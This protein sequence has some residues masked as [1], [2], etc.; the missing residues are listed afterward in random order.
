M[1]A[2]GANTHPLG[3]KAGCFIGV[4]RDWIRTREG[5]S[6]LMLTQP[7]ITRAQLRRIRLPVCILA[8][9]NDVIR[10]AHTRALAKSIPGAR[11]RVVPGADHGS[12][13]VGSD[14]F[15]E[16]ARL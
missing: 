15:I 4:L 3:V 8:G 11:L 16:E 14:R 12:Y 5:R 2:A 7:H 10:P 6:E 13:I 1:I 9:E